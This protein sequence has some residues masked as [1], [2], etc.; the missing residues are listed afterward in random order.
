M[1]DSFLPQVICLVKELRFIHI[2]NREHRKYILKRYLIQRKSTH[3][4]R[5][6]HTLPIFL[7]SNIL[8]LCSYQNFPGVAFLALKPQCHHFP[9]P[10]VVQ[11]ISVKLGTD[12]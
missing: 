1:P 9:N 6:E 4:M 11:N 10:E 5:D 12:F 2:A 8:P 3:A 7:F